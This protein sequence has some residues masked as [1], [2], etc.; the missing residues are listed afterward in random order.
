MV[1]LMNGLMA[2]AKALREIKEELETLNQLLAIMAN[3]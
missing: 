2:I 1:G 3:K